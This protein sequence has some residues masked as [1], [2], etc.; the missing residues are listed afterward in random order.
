MGNICKKLQQDKQENILH[1]RK[2]TKINTSEYFK[3]IRN[4]LHR[5][6]KENQ[7]NKLNLSISLDKRDFN[8]N[9]S[10]K[11]IH[12]NPNQ[13]FVYWKD[14]LLSYLNKKDIQGYQWATDLY[15]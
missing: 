3:L 9:V 8:S 10:S 13:K 7:N 1:S 12:L 14:Y 6:Y 5:F 15:K 2:W 11:T 4:Q